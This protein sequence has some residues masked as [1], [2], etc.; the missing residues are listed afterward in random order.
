MD[1]VPASNKLEA[2]IRISN[3]TNSGPEELGPGSKERKSVLINLAS[4]LGLELDPRHSK[5]QMANLLSENLGGQWDPIF[6]SAG[7]T[8]T[9]QGLN[10]L[11]KLASSR[12]SESPLIPDGDS[13]SLESEVR[14]IASVLV[15]IITPVFDGKTCVQLMK[16]L[17]DSNW[18]QPQ[19]QGFYF[20]MQAGNALMEKL[21]GGPSLILNT[22]FDYVKNF[23]WDLKAHGERDETGRVISECLLNDSAS[24]LQAIDQGG[25]GFIVLSGSQTYDREFSRWHKSYRGSEPGEPRRTL[26]SKFEPTSLEIFFVPTRARMAEAETNRQFVLKAQGKNSNNKPRPPKYSLNIDRARDSDLLVFEHK[27]VW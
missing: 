25:V 9:L 20:E 7:Q 4:G 24:V 14:Q 3:L 27:F 10:Y 18:R 22:K 1:F 12:L 17:D 13:S 21:G 23:T 2:V 8:I 15:P 5:Q 11:L 19:W 26:K 16:S 6:E